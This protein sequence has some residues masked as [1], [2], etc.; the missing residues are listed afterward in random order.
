M[1]TGGEIMPENAVDKIRQ[2]LYA[3]EYKFTP[4]RRMVLQV[5][6]EHPDEHLSADEIYSFVKEKHPD[7]GMATIYR[8]LDLLA[9]LGIVQKINFGDGKARFEMSQ[10]ESH[11]HHHLICLACNDIIEVKDDLLAHLEEL[12]SKEYGFEIQDHMVQFFGLCK[13]CQADPSRG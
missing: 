10:K 1:S 2:E 11:Q 3:N 7:I 4:Q 6:A 9:S 13:K 12:I 8:T 5:L